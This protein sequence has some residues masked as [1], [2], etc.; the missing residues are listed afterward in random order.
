MDKKLLKELRKRIQVAYTEKTEY[1][2][3]YKGDTNWEKACNYI[4]TNDYRRRKK[5]YLVTFCDL[6][7]YYFDTNGDRETFFKLIEKYFPE[8]IVHILENE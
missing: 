6:N 8:R 5:T 1:Y 2:N 3:N 4:L 7:L